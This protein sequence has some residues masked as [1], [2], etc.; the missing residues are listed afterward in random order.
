MDAC[1]EIWN[2]MFYEGKNGF[3]GSYSNGLIFLINPTQSN[4]MIYVCNKIQ[5]SIIL[6][7]LKVQTFSNCIFKW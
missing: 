2:P 4:D 3:S 6:L 1:S 7:I 5:Y